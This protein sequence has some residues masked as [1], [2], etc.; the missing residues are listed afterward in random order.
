MLISY[1]I[2]GDVSV[3]SRCVSLYGRINRDE[4][5]VCWWR[6]RMERMLREVRCC[7]SIWPVGLGVLHKLSW[8]ISALP[9]SLGT[10]TRSYSA[11]PTPSPLPSPRYKTSRCLRTCSSPIRSEVG[12]S[13]LSSL[14]SN[15]L[16]S[17]VSSNSLLLSAVGSE[18]G[19]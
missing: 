18:T 14:Q 2:K 13:L 5:E 11:T 3:C 12:S 6:A 7:C 9:C 4:S 1:L 17:L 10:M 15:S 8:L 16:I 19:A